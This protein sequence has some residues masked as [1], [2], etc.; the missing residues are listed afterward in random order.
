MPETDRCWLTAFSRS[1][2]T[3]WRW[4]A[5]LASSALDYRRRS[6][7]NTHADRHL[8]LICLPG[9]H[10]RRMGYVQPLPDCTTDR[11]YGKRR[12]GSWRLAVGGVS[13]PLPVAC[14]PP[15][16]ASPC[17]NRAHPGTCSLPTTS[18]IPFPASCI[19]FP[20]SCIPH[21]ASRFPHP[22]SRTLHP[23]SR[24]LH[25]ASRIPFP[26]SRFPHPASHILHPVSRILYPASCTPLGRRSNRV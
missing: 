3:R 16:R 6:C 7:H 24:I 20:A 4:L 22:V 11:L 9:Q 10:R 15:G 26:A 25:P 18:C 14:S 12:V 17:F 23:V 1:A 2:R 21:P 5:R 19:P 13:V 8:R